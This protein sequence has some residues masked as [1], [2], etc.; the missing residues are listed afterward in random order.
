MPDKANTCACL[1]AWVGQ[2]WPIVY[3]AL[4]AGTISALRV[5]YRQGSLRR[6]LVEALLCAALTLAASSG[7]AL[8]DI[9]DSAAPFVGG[10][11]GL[12][13]V[14]AIRALT[15]RLLGRHVGPP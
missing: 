10:L 3:A 15:L 2:H 6:T 9:A 5:I 13:G 8:L 12:L 1:S 4:L 7:L 14:E 11:V